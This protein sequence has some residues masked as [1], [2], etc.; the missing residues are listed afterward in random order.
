MPQEVLVEFRGTG[1]GGG[2]TGS[3]SSSSSSLGSLAAAA[4]SLSANKDLDAGGISPCLGACMRMGLA[5]GQPHSVMPDHLV[6][7]VR[8]VQESV[9]GRLH[10]LLVRGRSS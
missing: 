9:F 6:R 10:G 8:G 4:T 1:S 7:A 5:E 2:S 3:S